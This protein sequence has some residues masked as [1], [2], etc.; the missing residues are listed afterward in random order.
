MM[1]LPWYLGNSRMWDWSGAT[2]M[3][4]WSFG[5]FVIPFAVWSVLWTGMALWYAAKRDE[6]GWFIFFLLVHTLGLVEIL[7]LIFV[8]RAFGKEKRSPRRRR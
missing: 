5:W 2:M 1:G 4:G 3:S 8:A 7:Y 6:K